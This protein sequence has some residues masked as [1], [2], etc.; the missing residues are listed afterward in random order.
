MVIT[1]AIG[2]TVNYSLSKTLDL[3]MYFVV[4]MGVGAKAAGLNVVGSDQDG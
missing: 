1:K 3:L 4:A 2:E